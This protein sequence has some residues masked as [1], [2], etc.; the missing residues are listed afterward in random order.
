MVDHATRED[1]LAAYGPFAAAF[2]PFGD[3]T[4]PYL[5]LLHLDSDQAANVITLIRD[6]ARSDAATDYILVLLPGCRLAAAYCRCSRNVFLPHRRF[7]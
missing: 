6:V 7:D 5:S 4:T 2:E 1:M 3:D